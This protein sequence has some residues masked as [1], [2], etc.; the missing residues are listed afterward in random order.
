[1]DKVLA[2][3]IAN[4]ERSSVM[5]NPGR[6]ERKHLMG[7][8]EGPDLFSPPFAKG[9]TEWYALPPEGAHQFTLGEDV[10]FHRLLKSFPIG[11]SF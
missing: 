2:D 7:E 11:P 1:M 3:L 9:G 4:G 6:G 8:S 5:A 10:T